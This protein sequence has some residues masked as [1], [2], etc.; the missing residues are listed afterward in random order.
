MIIQ[1][2]VKSPLV[3]PE[4]ARMMVFYNYKDSHKIYSLTIKFELMIPGE[5]GFLEPHIRPRLCDA[6]ELMI[7]LA[8]NNNNLQKVLLRN[9]NFCFFTKRYGQPK[10]QGFDQ[11]YWKVHDLID[12]L[13]MK[14]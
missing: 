6:N 10:L 3:R 1:N 11:F 2:A 12:V 14:I 13:K 4:I 8:F 5:T 9:T 7:Q